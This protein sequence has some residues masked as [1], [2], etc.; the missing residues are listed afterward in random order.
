MR[1]GTTLEATF[2]TLTTTPECECCGESFVDPVALV[3][4]ADAVRLYNG[5]LERRELERTAEIA[6]TL[7]RHRATLDELKRQRGAQPPA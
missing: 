3:L 2:P 7:A 5:E 1:A 6:D 4:V